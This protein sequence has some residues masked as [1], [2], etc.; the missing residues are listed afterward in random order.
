M[1]S[2]SVI[3]HRLSLHNEDKNNWPEPDEEGKSCF[4][5]E[6]S[7]YFLPLFYSVFA[8]L[9]SFVMRLYNLRKTGFTKTWRQ[10]S[11]QRVSIHLL[12]RLNCFQGGVLFNLRLGVFKFHQHCAHYEYFSTPNDFW[13]ACVN[14]GL[15]FN[16]TYPVLWRPL[17]TSWKLILL[18]G[19]CSLVS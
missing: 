19:W 6:I 17:M 9:H 16:N 12:K 2:F 3:K 13:K 14:S 15:A 11:Y 1:L 4:I 8:P 10:N 18:N 5:L 7:I